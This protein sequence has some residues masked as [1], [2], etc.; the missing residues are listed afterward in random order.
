MYVALWGR[1]H[2][3]GWG[4]ISVAPLQWCL[5]RRN[6]GDF[7]PSCIWNVCVYYLMIGIT[8]L[9]T[10]AVLWSTC[11]NRHD[12]E[13]IVS[14]IPWLHSRDMGLSWHDVDDCVAHRKEFKTTTILLLLVF[15]FLFTGGNWPAT[16]VLYLVSHLSI[17][18]KGVD[19]KPVTSV[20]GFYV[21]TAICTVLGFTWFIVARPKIRSLQRV[22]HTAWKVQ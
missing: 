6:N 10:Y 20:D 12:S 16:I 7:Y 19:G 13:L 11:R 4:L 2:M 8:L 17:S 15:T 3:A 22:A 18:R 5:R 14:F 1:F 9:P 21:E